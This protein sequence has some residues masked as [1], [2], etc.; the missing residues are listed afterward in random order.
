MFTLQSIVYDMN[1]FILHVCIHCA[2]P[3]P[4]L[5]LHG[6]PFVRS[7]FSV[8]IVGAERGLRILRH[9]KLTARDHSCAAS[10]YD[11][12]NLMTRSADSLGANLAS[13]VQLRPGV[14]V[15]LGVGCPQR[16]RRVEARTGEGPEG[17]GFWRRPD[18]CGRCPF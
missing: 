9:A 16:K 2:K 7:W 17:N 5:C 1:S 3:I 12:G 10:D 4:R 8:F 15:Q 13:A 6:R 14:L 18:D 11:D